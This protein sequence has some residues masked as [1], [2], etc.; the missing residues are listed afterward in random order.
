MG[1]VELEKFCFI[2]VANK[3]NISRVDER[4]ILLSAKIARNATCIARE[5][6]RYSKYSEGIFQFIGSII[7]LWDC[8]FALRWQLVGGP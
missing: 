8:P 4:P 2:Q 3:C 5:R 1:E 6:A 7:K